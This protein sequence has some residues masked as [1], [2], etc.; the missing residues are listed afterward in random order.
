LTEL[1]VD[2]DG[3]P[4]ELTWS[5]D[6]AGEI[7]LTGWLGR[8]ARQATVEVGVRCPVRLASTRYPESTDQRLLGVPVAEIE[9][10]T[11]AG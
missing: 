1:E 3:S 4:V 11:R 8:A 7:V 2:L 9:L 6:P 5:G 10:L